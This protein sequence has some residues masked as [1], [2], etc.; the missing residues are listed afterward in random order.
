MASRGDILHLKRRL[1][2]A[3]RG[4][5]EPIVV[6]QADPL[7]RSLGTVLVVPLDPAL[8]L[9]DGNPTAVLVP[10]RES[11]LGADH[12][13]VLTHVRPVA[14]GHLAPAVVGRLSPQTQLA[15]DRVLKLVLGLR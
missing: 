3:A 2:F 9:Y 6:V 14:L 7:N 4:T 11:G 5:A 8:A 15:L 12:M 1:G 13:A 10:A